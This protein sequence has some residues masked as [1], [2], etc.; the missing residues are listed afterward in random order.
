[1]RSTLA[2]VSLALAVA[3]AAAEPPSRVV[4]ADIAPAACRP[5]TSS[6]L[7]LAVMWDQVLSLAACLLDGDVFAIS[8]PDAL[9]AMVDAMMERDVPAL[10]LDLLAIRTGTDD[11]AIRAAFQVGSAELALVVRA[12]SSLVPTARTSRAALGSRLEPLLAPVL[13]SA[14]LAFEGIVEAAAAA[15]A[16]VADPV[17]RNA[18]RAAAQHLRELPVEASLPVMTRR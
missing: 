14:R 5:F 7:V 16:A 6:P 8:D 10:Q 4:L 15:P 12:R 17:T 18:V 3:P 1:M 2:L 11:V 9:P 13:H